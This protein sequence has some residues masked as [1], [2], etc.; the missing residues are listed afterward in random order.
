MFYVSLQIY[1]N[2]KNYNIPGINIFLCAWFFV[3][4]RK[5]DLLSNRIRTLLFLLQTPCQCKKFV[6]RKTT[7]NQGQ[8]DGTFESH[9]HLFKIQYPPGIISCC[10]LQNLWFRNAAHSFLCG[11]CVLVTRVLHR[12]SYFAVLVSE[13]I[14]GTW[15]SNSCLHYV[16]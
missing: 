7:I 1:N 14:M 11:I 6:G 15:N 10:H 4:S 3:G 12:R 13:W 16:P 8:F 9:Q 2:R 5:R